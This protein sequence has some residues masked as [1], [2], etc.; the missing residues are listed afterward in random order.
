LNVVALGDTDV[1]LLDDTDVVVA[2]LRGRGGSTM[3]APSRRGRRSDV[4]LPVAPPPLEKGDHVVGV[5]LLEGEEVLEQPPVVSSLSCWRGAGPG[6]TRHV[7]PG[8]R[9]VS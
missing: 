9:G 3:V 1:V 6:A 2:R 7:D 5:F 8:G 4:A